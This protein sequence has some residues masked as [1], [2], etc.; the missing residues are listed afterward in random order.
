MTTPIGPD[1]KGTLH[2]GMQGEA[3][4]DEKY[5]M[6]LLKSRKSKTGVF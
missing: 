6:R 3:K 2:C 4:R 5:A 1:E